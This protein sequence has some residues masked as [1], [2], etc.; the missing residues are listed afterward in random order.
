MST[1]KAP[2]SRGLTLREIKSLLECLHNAIGLHSI[3]VM[4]D[5]W[6]VGAADEIKFRVLNQRRRY[7]NWIRRLEA[8]EEILA[9]ASSERKQTKFDAKKKRRKNKKSGIDFFNTRSD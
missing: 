1:T 2:R 9:E 3:Y 4:H 5:D 8:E 6:H 7:R